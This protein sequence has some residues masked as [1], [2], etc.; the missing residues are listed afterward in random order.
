METLHEGLVVFC[1]WLCTD[2]ADA[3]ESGD[4]SS[5]GEDGESDSSITTV[6][7]SLY[8]DLVSIPQ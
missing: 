1:P 7:C 6:R 4:D 5:S 2:D 8:L 3:A